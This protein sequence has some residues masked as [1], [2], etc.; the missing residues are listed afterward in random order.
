MKL[1][2][3]EG[4]I[5]LAQ[6][7]STD[8]WE[9]TKGFESHRSGGCERAADVVNLLKSVMTNLPFHIAAAYFVC[10]SSSRSAG[11]SHGLFGSL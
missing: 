6:M 1:A 10:A 8:V 7:Y 5:E 2:L 4:K 11:T 3:E 9:E